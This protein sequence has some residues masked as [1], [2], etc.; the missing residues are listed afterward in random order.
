MRKSEKLESQKQKMYNNRGAIDINVTV[1][2]CTCFFLFWWITNLIDF[3]FRGLFLLLLRFRLLSFLRLH[4]C[5]WWRWEKIMMNTWRFSLSHFLFFF[6]LSPPF[7]DLF[8][9][10]EVWQ[11]VDRNKLCP[12]RFNYQQIT[13][14]RLLLL[15]RA[16]PPLKVNS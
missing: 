16:H 4:T 10:N 6:S 9:P 8:P 7:V 3:D 14:W 13:W 11:F 5:W 15:G 1:N 2:L 12:S